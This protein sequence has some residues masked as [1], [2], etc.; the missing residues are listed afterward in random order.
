MYAHIILALYLKFLLDSL[1]FVA[2]ICWQNSSVSALVIAH[3]LSGVKM[4]RDESS[5]HKMLSW[6]TT[7]MV[8]SMA[9]EVQSSYP[10]A[11]YIL[12]LRRYC[13][14]SGLQLYLLQAREGRRGRSRSRK[15]EER[16]KYSN[17]LNSYQQDA[18]SQEM[19][20]KQFST[21]SHLLQQLKE[22]LNRPKCSF[23]KQF[24]AEG[25]EGL[26]LLLDILRVIQLSQANLTSGLD[27]NI[28]KAIFNKALGD[29]HETLLCIK[30]CVEL[31]VG[32]RL[33]ADHPS[34]L[35]TISVCVMSNCNKSRVLALQ[36][37]EQMCRIDVGHQ[38]VG[39]A[40]TMLRL[41]FGEPVRFKFIVGKKCNSYLRLKL[42]A[43]FP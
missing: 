38:K 41:R 7:C 10:V 17:I 33:V 24:L 1:H 29:E 13:Q 26:S 18:V 43:K 36:I 32:L 27:Q 3:N 22:D 42:I 30:L 15:R 14:H 6:G 23:R 11:A 25:S 37:L 12:H 9:K 2:T 19:G 39:D 40:I 35:F 28:N 31:D 5:R 16:E 8:S 4:S 20:F 34:G 21:I